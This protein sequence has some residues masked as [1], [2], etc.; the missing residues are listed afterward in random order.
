L[1]EIKALEF[2]RDN[3][4]NIQILQAPTSSR[5]PIKP[6]KKRNVMITAL[7]G[8]FFLMFFSFLLEYLLKNRNKKKIAK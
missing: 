6:K 2:K 8:F 5:Y 4:Q 7:S 3:I 1:E